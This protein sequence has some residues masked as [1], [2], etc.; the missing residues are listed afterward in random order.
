MIIIYNS[1]G[2]LMGQSTAVVARQIAE[3]KSKP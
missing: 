1:L 2:D 3:L